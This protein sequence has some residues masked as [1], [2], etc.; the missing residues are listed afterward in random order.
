MGCLERGGEERIEGVT[1]KSEETFGVM[2][3]F[4]LFIVVEGSQV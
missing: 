1:K 3:I 2:D 4:T